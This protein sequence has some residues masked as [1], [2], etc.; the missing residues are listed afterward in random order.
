[1][2][3]TVEQLLDE[4]RSRHRAWSHSNPDEGVWRDTG[5]LAGAVSI[6]GTQP[7]RDAA[8]AYEIVRDDMP[9]LMGAIQSVLNLHVPETVNEGDDDEATV[10]AECGAIV[11]EGPCP[12]VQTI[13][14]GLP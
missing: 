7:V 14:E 1:M 3:V 12:T 6:C 8:M 9:R 13:L 4:Y 2:T 11:D 5:L 10:C